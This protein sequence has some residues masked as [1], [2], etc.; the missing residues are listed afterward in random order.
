MTENELL[1]LL[2]DVRGD[3]IAQTEAFRQGKLQ[4]KRSPRLLPIAAIFAVVLLAGA[5]IQAFLVPNW[6]QGTEEPEMQS[7]AATAAEAETAVEES[8]W[9]LEILDGTGSF[10]SQDCEKEMTFPSYTEEVQRQRETNRISPWRYAILDMDGNGTQELVI[11]YRM[12]DNGDFYGEEQTLVFWQTDQRILE[13][14]YYTRQMRHIRAD[15]AFYWSGSSS[16]SGWARLTGLDGENPSEMNIPEDQWDQP[17]ADWHSFD[18]GDAH[19]QAGPSADELLR[20]REREITYVDGEGNVA[21]LETELFIGRGYSIYVP[22][23]GWTYTQ[24]TYGGLLAD[25]WTYDWNPEINLRIVR[26]GGNYDRAE[27]WIRE[28]ES[29]WSFFWDE[30]GGLYGERDGKDMN[31]S[32]YPKEVDTIVALCAFPVEAYEGGGRTLSV[33]VDTFSRWPTEVDMLYPEATE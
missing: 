14:G 13:R 29:A 1:D 17:E 18:G 31:V 26:V 20:L 2:T 21:A 27:A 9:Q 11:Q 5:A 7:F 30:Q 3:Y 33:L 32:F 22:K 24:E 28:T 15:G 23:E 4:K 10:Y 8:T 16:N 25:K 12:V 19:S 6:K